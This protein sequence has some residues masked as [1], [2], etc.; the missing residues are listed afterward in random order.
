MKKLKL[1]DLE[2]CDG[3]YH[4]GSIVDIDGSPWVT[5]DQA[6][7]ALDIANSHVDAFMDVVKEKTDKPK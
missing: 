1:T 4:V 5:K 7:E 3:L 2:T 6:L